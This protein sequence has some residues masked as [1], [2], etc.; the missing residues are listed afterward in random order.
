MPYIKKE[1]RK[2]YQEAINAL[3]EAVPRDRT[4]RPGHM[5]YIVSLLIER[6]YGEQMRYC[7]HNEVL[8]FL[9]GVQLEFYRRKTAP[10]EDEKIISEGDLNDL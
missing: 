5:N 4:A 9:E 10:Y 7:D 6:V 3:A 2:V 1:E 8:G